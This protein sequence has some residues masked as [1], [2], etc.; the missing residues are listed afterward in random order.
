MLAL[1]AIPC[2]PMPLIVPHMAYM[3]QLGM[4]VIARNGA[5][6]TARSTISASVVKARGSYLRNSMSTML[7]RR[8][9]SREIF[10][11][12]LENRFPCIGYR[13]P[14]APPISV[15]RAR[16]RPIGIVMRPEWTVLR[17]DMAER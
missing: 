15:Q 2:N 7:I 3:P 10:R 14:R 17:I 16:L 12:M 8:P 11:P 9:T 1:A 5:A 4:K 6:S 13:L